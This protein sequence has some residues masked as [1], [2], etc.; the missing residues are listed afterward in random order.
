MKEFENMGKRMPYT[1][2]PEYVSQLIERT[3]EEAIRQTDHLRQQV[4]IRPLI[5]YAAAAAI[6]ALMVF[7]AIS[8][9]NRTES[10]Q[11]AKT[12]S[13][14]PIDDFLASLSDEDVQLLAY[15]D[16]EDAI[17]YE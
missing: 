9:W 5:R 2:N 10:Q 15:Y 16:I 11:I 17:D 8:L 1:E 7:S 12:E 3:T 4:T 6:A 13:V 14:S